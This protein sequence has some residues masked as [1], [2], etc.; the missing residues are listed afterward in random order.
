MLSDEDR[1]LFLD[2][3]PWDINREYFEVLASDKPLYLAVFVDEDQNP[4]LYLEH[5]PI[6]SMPS[7]CRVFFRKDDVRQ[8]IQ[9]IAVERRIPEVHL[10]AWE[11]SFSHLSQFMPKFDAT[12]KEKGRSGVFATATVIH[13]HQFKNIDVFW[14]SAKSFMV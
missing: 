11:S 10:R 1:Y 9:T 2:L 14:T 7:A 5:S 8:Y 4:T 13:R 12:L 6:K 3:P